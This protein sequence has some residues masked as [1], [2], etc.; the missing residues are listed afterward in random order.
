MVA[1]AGHGRPS[2]Q[3]IH[4]RRFGSEADI[5]AYVAIT[6]PDRAPSSFFTSGKSRPVG[7]SAEDADFH[8]SLDGF[9]FDQ[10]F[11]RVSSTPV[12]ISS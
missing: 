9:L 6:E 10:L 4:A 8:L 12:S 11:S 3:N 7:E 1:V 2:S 5:A